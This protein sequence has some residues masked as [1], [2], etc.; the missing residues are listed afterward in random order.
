[1]LGGCTAS[2]ALQ[3]LANGEQFDQILLRQLDYADADPRRAR[4]KTILQPPQSLSQRPSANAEL[5][6]DLGFG[7]PLPWL[8]F[9]GDYGLDDLV[10]RL[11]GDRRGMGDGFENRA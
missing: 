9:A 11:S 6:R 3:G 2:H 8:E 10:E 5:T 1:M 4:D 7:D